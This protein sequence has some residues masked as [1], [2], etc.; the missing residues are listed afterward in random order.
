MVTLSDEAV[1]LISHIH[2][3][4]TGIRN[5]H[6]ATSLALNDNLNRRQKKFLNESV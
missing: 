6:F 1:K 4:P 3:H 2:D 5:C